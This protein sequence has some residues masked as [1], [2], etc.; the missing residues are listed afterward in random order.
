MKN[1]NIGGE[2]V[3]DIAAILANNINLKE[4]DLGGNQSVDG[5]ETIE[6]LQ[7][8]TSNNTSSDEE[9]DYATKIY[10]QLI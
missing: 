1:N 3:D 9:T 10:L 4:L 5:I 2:A 7:S 8:T 6:D